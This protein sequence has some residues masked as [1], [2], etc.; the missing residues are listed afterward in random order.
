MARLHITALL[1]P[2]Q[3]ERL[4][5]LRSLKNEIVGHDQKK[6]KWVENGIIEPVV[7]IL[8]SSRSSPSTNGKD[9]S[10]GRVPASRPLTSEESVR[11]QA[12]QV[13]AS[14]A[15]GGFAFL[16]PILAAGALSAILSNIP[17]SDNPPRV[18]V[19]ALRA[20]VNI[21]E[22]STLAPPTSATDIADLAGVAFVPVL[23][24]AFRDILTST[25][26]NHTIQTQKNL[27]AKLI[28]LLCREERSRVDL[29]NHGIL[30]ALATNLA[31]VVVARGFVVPGAEA[32]AQSEGVLD[33]IPGPAAPNTDVTAILEALSAIL[34]DSRWRASVLVGAPALVAV[35]P[36][37]GSPR[38]SKGMKACVNS[39]EVAGLSSIASKDLGAL[40]CFLPVVPEYQAK[41]TTM[42][43]YP[44]VGSPP[45]RDYLAFSKAPSTK[46]FASSFSL[47]TAQADTGGANAEG[48]VEETESPL[49]PW[50]LY[51]IRSTE[52]M[53]RVMAASVLTSLHRAGLANKSRE[54]YMGHL[55]VPILLQA[56]E[57]IG[58]TCGA[59]SEATFVDAKTATK[60]SI[61]ER[62]LAI[63]ARLIVDSEF[64]QKCAFECDGVKI[65][66]AYL[67]SAYE[68]LASKS[69]KAWSPSAGRENTGEREIGLPTSRLG[70]GG[71]LPLQV[72]RTRVRENALKAIAGLAAS[73]DDYR[74]ALVEQDLV[75]FIVESLSPNPSNPKNKDR[76]KSPKSVTVDGDGY[77]S[78]YGVNPITVI[79]A[80]CHA[81][82][83][84]ARS[85]SIL[86]TTLEDNAVATPAFRLLRHPD[87]DIQ[88][89]ASALMCNLVTD[90]APMREYLNGVGVMRTLCE[91]TRSQNPALRLNA[92]WAL[93][94]WINGVGMDAKKECVEELSTGWLVHL[95]CDDTEDDALY[96]RTTKSKKQTANDM[97]E[98]VEMAQAGEESPTSGSA[99]PDTTT[100][101][102]SD[103][104]G[105]TPRLRQNERKIAELRETE[106]SLTRK[107]R[108][109]DLAVQ[110]QGLQF[111][112]NLIG[113]ASTATDS[114]RDHADMIDYLFNMLGQDRFFELLHSKLHLKYLHP[115]GRRY[116]TSREPRVLYPQARI[117]SAVVYILV[118]MAASVPRHRQ[119][120]ISQSELLKDLAKH[121]HS[122]DKDVRVALCHLMT[123][124]TWR[125]DPDDEDS[126]RQR[127]GELKKLG[128]LTKLETLESDD[129][130]LDV[131][132]R[133]KA[134]I[135][136]ISQPRREF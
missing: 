128:L 24:D 88:I 123:N 6:E 117:V 84:L 36:H 113:P 78:A 91:Q 104:Q 13:L 73:K 109:D 102:A 120:L 41:G 121:F 127:A 118:H 61:I 122:K 112:R 46:Y 86:R 76:P 50:L 65:V 95:I 126:S 115:F 75:P 19:A 108:D 53:E 119:V 49:I 103:E 98:D 70:P 7:K 68:P 101:P 99:L 110:E 136:Q 124:L 22:A 16:A 33:L 80:A 40:D 105:R 48:V 59:A 92:L 131:R 106:L 79:V 54:A 96:E 85:V 3:E 39:L 133:A 97:D 34:A 83:M 20:T 82:R 111:V 90:V 134:A 10:R 32:I 100:L 30:D 114:A 45:P 64:L 60:W 94:N 21:A 1:S 8:E 63:L 69:S 67:K 51:T 42:P 44:L 5:A 66:S 107:V 26:I 17:P 130:E 15:N 52:G 55:I 4:S 125:D 87:I 14:L 71:Q 89:A 62:C 25:P 9:S 56:L 132:E 47:D 43:S 37:P 18:V 135:W 74:K 93:K 129:E 28:G 57:D 72:H 77:D 58:I 116:P 31:A 12:L 35:F 11:L 29:T 81:L 27:A 23:L 2:D 38:R